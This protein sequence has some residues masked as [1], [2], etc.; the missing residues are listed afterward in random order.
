VRD[1][2]K[3]AKEHAELVNPNSFIVLNNRIKY[4][5]FLSTSLPLTPHQTSI[6]QKITLISSTP[7][8]LEVFMAPITT[9]EETFD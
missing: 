6:G 3:S 9:F 7:H 5:E 1:S 2:G 8:Y 4:L